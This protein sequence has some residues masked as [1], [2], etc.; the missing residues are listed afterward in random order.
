MTDP[1]NR[2]TPGWWLI[3]FTLVGVAIW[4]GA[5]RLVVGVLL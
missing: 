5:I 2:M 3:P 1:E 4:Y